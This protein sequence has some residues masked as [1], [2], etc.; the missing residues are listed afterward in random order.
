MSLDQPRPVPTID[1]AIA[2]VRADQRR[3][4]ANRD[5]AERTMLT[6]LADVERYERQAVDDDARIEDLFEERAAAHIRDLADRL[7]RP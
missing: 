5:R 3:K 6:A 7:V 1:Q 2:A 4:L